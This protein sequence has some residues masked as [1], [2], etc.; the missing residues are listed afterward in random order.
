MCQLPN[1]YHIRHDYTGLSQPLHTRQEMFQS[2][3]TYGEVQTKHKLLMWLP[4]GIITRTDSHAT[5]NIS[6]LP[7]LNS[8]ILVCSI[9]HF[10]QIDL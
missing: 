1:V 5:E 9:R 6:H 2:A 8:S 4:T 3:G 7:T 10:Q